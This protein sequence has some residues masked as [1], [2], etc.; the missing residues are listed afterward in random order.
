MHAVQSA[1]S[2]PSSLPYLLTRRKKGRK[3]KR[4]KHSPAQPSTTQYAT[5]V[6]TIWIFSTKLKV[7]A[8]GSESFEIHTVIV[9]AIVVVVVVEESELVVAVESSSR[10][11]AVLDDDGGCGLIGG[12]GGFDVFGG[13]GLVEGAGAGAVMV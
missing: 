9:D 2:L 1:I 13:G 11:P 5:T 12:G 7:K 3:R 10:F 4:G 6:T 8:Q